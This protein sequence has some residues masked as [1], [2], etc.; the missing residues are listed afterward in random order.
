MYV[1]W[2]KN[3]LGTRVDI[4]L[5]NLEG[6]VSEHYLRLNF[7]VTNNEAKYKDFTVGLTYASKLMVLELHVFNDLKL[8]VIRSPK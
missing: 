5:E 3:N 8:A 4:V 2:A 6:A 1:D 7:P